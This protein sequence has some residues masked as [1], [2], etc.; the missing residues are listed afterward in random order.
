ME[1][2]VLVKD[3]VQPTVKLT[4]RAAWLER[5]KSDNPGGCNPNDTHLLEYAA[6]KMRMTRFAKYYE[7]LMN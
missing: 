5:F 2:D 1:D 4:G 7:Y 6:R 3:A